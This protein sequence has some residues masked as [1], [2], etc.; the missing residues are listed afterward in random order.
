MKR[1]TFDEAKKLISIGIYPKCEVSREVF[2][3]VNS[4]REL[5]NL[6]NLSSIQGFTLYG[7]EEREIEDFKVPDDSIELS[8]NEALSIILENE[9]IYAKTIGGKEEVCFSSFHSLS[10][11]IKECESSGE[12]FLLYWRA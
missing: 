8:I 4:F 11:F 7:Y 12:Q 1:I 5:E 9:N 2:K 10:S 3:P 6:R